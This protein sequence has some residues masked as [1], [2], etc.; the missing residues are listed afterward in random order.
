MGAP[1][2]KDYRILG[3]I[4]GSAY[5]G[6]LPY[7][8]E[9]QE[10]RISRVEEADA[11]EDGSKEV[12]WICWGFIKMMDTKMENTIIF[13]GIYW[14]YIGITV[15]LFSFC[16]GFRLTDVYAHY[17]GTIQTNCGGGA[18]DTLGTKMNRVSELAV[19][20]LPG[21]WMGSEVNA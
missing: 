2:K 5:L 9:A 8:T 11:L 6:K 10:G 1:Y 20:A 18:A 17:V 7:G 12:W 4:L 19:L 14:G 13:K 21:I 16:T 15:F 3:S